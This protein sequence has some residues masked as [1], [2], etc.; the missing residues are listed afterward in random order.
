VGVWTETNPSDIRLLY[1]YFYR[2]N[3]VLRKG[4]ATKKKKGWGLLLSIWVA[5][6]SGCPNDDFKN[7]GSTSTTDIGSTSTTNTGNNTGNTGSTSTIVPDEHIG[8]TFAIVRGDI[9][10]PN[11][12][13]RGV[14]YS[15]AP[16][17]TTEDSK[18][19]DSGD[20]TDTS[21][22]TVTLNGLTPSTT[23]Y[24]RSYAMNAERTVYGDE[25]SFKTLAENNEPGPPVSPPSPPPVQ[26][27]PPPI[28]SFPP[29]L[30]IKPTRNNV[31]KYS[32][33]DSN[34]NNQSSAGVIVGNFW[35][36]HNDPFG[37]RIQNFILYSSALFFDVHSQIAGKNIRKAELWLHVRS[38]ALQKNTQYGIAA[39]AGPWGS[40]ITANNMP[41]YYTASQTTFVP[42]TALLTVL[43]VT[44]IVRNWANGTW[45]NNG[46]YLFDRN[47]VFPYNSDTR[48][49][50]FHD[51]SSELP[52]SLHI[53]FQ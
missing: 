40:N 18:V 26:L 31:M 2:E 30:S 21:P 44:D 16:T 24:V 9:S 3:N 39:F 13:E 37:T 47:A 36:M 20:G 5:A 6:L 23:Y 15:T 42:P 11:S 50:F 46:F 29:P 1:Q 17:P 51:T 49:T 41:Q 7:T 25:Q 38:F 43:D 53:E 45:V 33:M 34:L 48:V 32:N 35:V 12:T 27:P 10:L 28:S 52:P 8:S 14:C 22:F 4:M 19:V